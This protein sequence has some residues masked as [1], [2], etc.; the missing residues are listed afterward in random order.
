MRGQPLAA[1]ARFAISS[2][3][4]VL[5]MPRAPTSSRGVGVR[6]SRA[7]NGDRFVGRLEDVVSAGEHR[8]HLAE[9]DAIR[10]CAAPAAFT[11]CLYHAVL[12]LDATPNGARDA[13]AGARGGER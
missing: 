7:A 8:W 10:A 6:A 1:A 2:N 4:T 5:P 9:P 3:S 12:L 11:A 13:P